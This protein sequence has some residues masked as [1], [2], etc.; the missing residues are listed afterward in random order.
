MRLQ[1]HLAKTFRTHGKQ[2]ASV[3]RIVHDMPSLSDI[4]GEKVN[5]V[6]ERHDRLTKRI[7]AMSDL[8]AEVELNRLMSALETIAKDIS[9]IIAMIEKEI[10]HIQLH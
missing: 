6:S 4:V 1:K 10:H 7:K 5:D 8:T 2:L 9:S 3:Q